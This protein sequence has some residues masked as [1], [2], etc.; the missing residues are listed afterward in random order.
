MALPSGGIARGDAVSPR[1]RRWAGWLPLP[2]AARRGVAAGLRAPVVGIPAPPPR[3]PRD[4]YRA[5]ARGHGLG[6]G[7]VALSPQLAGGGRVGFSQSRRP[8][9]CPRRTEAPRT[10]PLVARP[11]GG[12][13]KGTTVSRPSRPERLTA[14]GADGAAGQR[15]G[16][17]SPWR[18][19]FPLASQVSAGHLPCFCMGARDGLG[20]S[21]VLP[22]LLG[23]RGTFSRGLLRR[24]PRISGRSIPR[25]ARGA[26][27][28]FESGVPATSSPVTL[29][30]Q[31]G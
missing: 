7:S 11:S 25:A 15:C 13:R 3:T 6:P 5:T 12:S 8:L 18:W 14:F 29:R 21:P 2:W 28:D 22:C 31:G 30:R 20:R 17:R 16:P 10:A 26:P 9:R 19:A 24:V 4:T 23:G 27:E 1:F